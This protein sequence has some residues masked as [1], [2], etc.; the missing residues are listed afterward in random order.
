MTQAQMEI[1]KRYGN[2]VI[3]IDGTHGLNNYSFQLYT[4]LTLDECREGFPCSFMFTNRGDETV[5]NMFLEIIK[6]NMG[7]LSPNV[8]MSDMEEGFYSAWKKIWVIQKYAFF[9]RG[10]YLRLGGLT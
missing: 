3:C 10:M 4:I 9:V 1:L 8:F 5:L 2:E 6:Q 7:I